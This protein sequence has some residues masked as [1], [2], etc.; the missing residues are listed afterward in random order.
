MEV[1]L[2]T[3]SSVSVAVRHSGRSCAAAGSDWMNYPASLNG[4]STQPVV[5]RL[6]QLVFCFDQRLSPA[7]TERA[8]DCFDL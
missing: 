6:A 2:T 1:H 7:E 4:G 5:R 3:S 8:I